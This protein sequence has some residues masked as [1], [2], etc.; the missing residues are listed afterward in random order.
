MDGIVIAIA[1]SLCKA[2]PL[3]QTR[4]PQIIIKPARLDVMHH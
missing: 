3:T 2:K 1:K 4:G